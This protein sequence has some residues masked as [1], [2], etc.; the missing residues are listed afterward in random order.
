MYMV[1]ACDGNQQRY[2]HYIVMSQRCLKGLKTQYWPLMLGQDFDGDY[3][4]E[5]SRVE[6]GRLC[7]VSSRASSTAF[8]LCQYVCLP[9]ISN[10]SMGI[11]LSL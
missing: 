4:A 11:Q 8:T 10:C 1:S 6:G 3:S 2:I 7:G 9:Y 5:Q